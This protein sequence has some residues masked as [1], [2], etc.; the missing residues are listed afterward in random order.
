M[1]RRNTKDTD[2]RQRIE[3]EKKE[4]ET[5]I[6][7]GEEAKKRLLELLAERQKEI[8]PEAG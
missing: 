8:Q 6:R 7:K 1:P 5:Q 3:A 4:Q 2:Y